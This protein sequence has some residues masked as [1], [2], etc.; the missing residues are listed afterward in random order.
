M[1]SGGIRGLGA[2]KKITEHRRQIIT[3]IG[4][5]QIGAMAHAADTQDRDGAPALAASIR[6]A[7]P[8]L[9]HVF[10]DGGD[11]RPKFMEAMPNSIF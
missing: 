7:V 1:K 9:C 11:A 6:S 8:W 3:D 4:G 5:F 2:G 10:A